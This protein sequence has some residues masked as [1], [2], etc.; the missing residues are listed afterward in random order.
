MNKFRYVDKSILCSYDL[1]E[2]NVSSYDNNYDNNFNVRY[3]ND[4]N[5]ENRIIRLFGRQQYPGSNKWE[6]YVTVNSGLDNIK[7]P[8]DIRRNELYSGDHVYL[9]ELNSKYRVRLYNYDAPRYYP[10]LI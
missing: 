3:N 1:S 9:P 2:D 6:Y 5:R 10:D 4:D 7:I 8:L